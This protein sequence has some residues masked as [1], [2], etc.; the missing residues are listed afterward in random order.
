MEPQTLI[1][2]VE[3]VSTREGQAQ[4]VLQREAIR[5]YAALH[6]PQVV[7]TY[8]DPERSGIQTK[9]RTG[10]R[11]LIRGALRGVEKCG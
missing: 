8:A 4:I 6:G 7:A 1:P 2:A 11:Q 5:R 3:C 10:L 9:N